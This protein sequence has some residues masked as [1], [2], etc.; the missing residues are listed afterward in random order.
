MFKLWEEDLV[1]NLRHIAIWFTELFSKLA[2]GCHC[3]IET[4]C[5]HRQ[6]KWS[7]V[8]L[9]TSVPFYRTAMRCQNTD[10]Q[11]TN[12]YC[13]GNLKSCTCCFLVESHWI[14][15]IKA[16]K[17]EINHHYGLLETEIH[18]D[19]KAQR[20]INKWKKAVGGANLWKQI[21][22]RNIWPTIQL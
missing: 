16:D 22:K 10:D 11:N 12:L 20:N 13:G 4:H 15:E 14:T 3:F 5:L 1:W 7:T 8:L 9:R 21:I 2:G 17:K 19:Y 18:K 6:L